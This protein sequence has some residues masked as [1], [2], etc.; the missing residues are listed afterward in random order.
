MIN[1]LGDLT[2][3]RLKNRKVTMNQLPYNLFF[4]LCKISIKSGLA[5]LKQCHHTN[6]INC[7]RHLVNFLVKGFMINTCI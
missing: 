6:Q 5:A 4:Y 2:L 7:M 3:F 1:E